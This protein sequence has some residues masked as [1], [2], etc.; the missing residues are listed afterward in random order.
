[1]ILLS[2]FSITIVNQGVVA[3]A[4]HFTLVVVEPFFGS[5]SS[6]NTPTVSISSIEKK[7]YKIDTFITLE[8]SFATTH[9]APLLYIANARW[10]ATEWS[11]NGAG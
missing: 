8:E 9:L 1:M 7:C 10:R 6:I 3:I 5:L 4:F 11:T 2:S